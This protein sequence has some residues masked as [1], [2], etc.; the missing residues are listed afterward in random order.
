VGGLSDVVVADLSCRITGNLQE[1]IYPRQLQHL[2]RGHALTV[3]G[4][5]PPKAKALGIQVKGRN[6]QGKAEELVLSFD[7]ADA[8]KVGAELATAWAAQKIYYLIGEWTVTGDEALRKEI[9]VLANQYSILV[10]Y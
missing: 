10:P 7:L 8:T 6:R 1:D 9:A 2:F 3:Y 4:K 5:V